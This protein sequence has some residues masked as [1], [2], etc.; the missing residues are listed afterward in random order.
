M[1]EYEYYGPVLYFDDV[2]EIRYKAKT[3][4][5][6]MAKARSNMTYKYKIANGYPPNAKITLPGRIN[7]IARIPENG[8][9]TF[10]I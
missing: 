5:P 1:Y 10:D 4:A 9:L 7:Q 2:I 3:V 8:Q 6:S